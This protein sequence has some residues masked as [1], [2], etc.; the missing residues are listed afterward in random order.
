MF[1]TIKQ[2]LTAH[3]PRRALTWFVLFY[4]SSLFVYACVEVIL[5]YVASLIPA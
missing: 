4:A 3:R 5:H 1:L 2:W